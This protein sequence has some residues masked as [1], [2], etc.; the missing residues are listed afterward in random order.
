MP[1]L[2]MIAIKL[3]KHVL[4][5]AKPQLYCTIGE[6]SLANAHK[7]ANTNA[8]HACTSTHVYIDSVRFASNINR[9][10]DAWT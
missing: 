3:T 6:M 7:Y 1:S 8:L 2:H 10:N 5:F 4:A 9:T